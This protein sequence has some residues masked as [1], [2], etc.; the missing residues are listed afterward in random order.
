MK[1][2][3]LSTQEGRNEYANS[4]AEKK[5]AIDKKAVIEGHV[6]DMLANSLKEMEKKL[7]SLFNSGAI[8]LNAY[9][10]EHNRMVLPKSIV[11]ALFESE[12]HQYKGTGTSHEK[13]VKKNVKNFR[14]FV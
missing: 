11:V 7:T 6:K 1:P 9:D 13:E 14:Y 8:E 10:T 5:A 4:D 2:H 3:D 12:A